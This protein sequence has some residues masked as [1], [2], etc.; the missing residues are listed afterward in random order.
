MS[1]RESRGLKI[2][3]SFWLTIVIVLMVSMISCQ[4]EEPE[5]SF[6][7]FVTGSLKINTTYQ[8]KNIT[9]FDVVLN[10]VDT[11]TISVRG[12]LNITTPFGEV[13][14][15]LNHIVI[16]GEFVRFCSSDYYTKNNIERYDNEIIV[17]NIN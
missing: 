9:S 4:K 15:V 6:P 3:M 11:N 13:T 14:E 7:V 5:S 1:E 12:G 2:R 17:S 8:L 16:D 10:T